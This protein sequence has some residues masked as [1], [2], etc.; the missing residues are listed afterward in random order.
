MILQIEVG[1]DNQVNA[2]GPYRGRNNINKEI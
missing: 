1:G 2:K